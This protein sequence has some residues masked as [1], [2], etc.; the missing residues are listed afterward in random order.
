MD[1]ETILLL[2]TLVTILLGMQ[3]F[4]DNTIGDNFYDNIIPVSFTS[5]NIGDNFN[6]NTIY[7]E[8]RKNSILNG[9]I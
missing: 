2:V 7:F 8:F 4:Y 6:T 3:F 1:S 9:L 5:N